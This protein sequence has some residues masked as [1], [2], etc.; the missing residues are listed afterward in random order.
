MK[1]ATTKTPENPRDEPATGPPQIIHVL[2]TE[3]DPRG[4][5]LEIDGDDIDNGSVRFHTSG[6]VLLFHRAPGKALS[7]LEAAQHTARITRGD[8]HRFRAIFASVSP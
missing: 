1:T 8:R 7:G 2:T 4:Q 5:E 6:G 3:D